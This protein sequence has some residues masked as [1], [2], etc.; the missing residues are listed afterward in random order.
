MSRKPGLILAAQSKYK[1][2][3]IFPQ[4]IHPELW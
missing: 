4:E 3:L 1:L 2:A